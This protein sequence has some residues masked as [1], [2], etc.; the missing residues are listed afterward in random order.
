[1]KKEIE[2]AI[3]VL[4]EAVT[5]Q[6]EGP[7]HIVVL[8]RGWI[9]VGDLSQDPVNQMYALSNCVNIRK[10]SKLGFGG[11]SKSAKESGA[12]LDNCAD[13]HFHPR[14]MVFCVPINGD[15]DE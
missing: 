1:M 8:D 13:I 7:R 5:E 6:P 3:N 9:F 4:K 11:L 12:T 15:W 14:A 2:N 10:W